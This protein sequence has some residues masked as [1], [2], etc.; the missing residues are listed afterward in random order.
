VE[1]STNKTIKTLRF[2]NSRKPKNKT[3]V[4]GKTKGTRAKRIKM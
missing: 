3:G 2:G 1:K 4:G